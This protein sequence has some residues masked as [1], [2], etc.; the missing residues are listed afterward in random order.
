MADD[1]EILPVSASDLERVTGWLLRRLRLPGEEV[2]LKPVS[3]RVPVWGRTFETPEPELLNSFFLEDLARVRAAFRS[4]NV[5]AALAGFVCGRPTRPAADV[6][7]NP[8]VLDET[9]SPSR[10][11]PS[12]WPLR[13]GY[14]LVLMQQAAV[15]HAVHEL[16]EAGLVGIN[17]PPGTGKTTLLRDIVAKVVLDRSTALLTFE[18]PLEAFSHVASM[19]SGRGY[20]HLYQLDES[21]LGHEVV[22]ASSNNKAV[23]NISREI[24]GLNA[25]AGDREPPLRYFASIADLLQRGSEP[26]VVEEGAAWGLAAAVL[27]NAANRSRFVNAFWWHPQRSM[28]K[29]LRGIVD[30]WNPKP[31]GSGD[32]KGAETLPEVLILEHAPAD[33]AEALARWHEVQ[34]RFKKAHE[35]CESERLALEEFREALHAR[36]GTEES[37]EAVRVQIDA[38]QQQLPSA[39]REVT[40][41]EGLLERG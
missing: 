5:G 40:V 15:N 39:T 36:S 38:L 28:Q 27:G 31:P 35:R 20:L 22:V 25:I 37:L 10:I 17:G 12:R 41:A 4:G 13:G 23:E 16:A 1:G 9:L 21:L 11:P 34:K 6:V 7:R 19:A 3:V 26:A 2:S 29:Y 24:P 14:P 30:G 32:E 8:P 33:R 18:D